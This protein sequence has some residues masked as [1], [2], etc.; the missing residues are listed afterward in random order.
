M[1]WRPFGAKP[2]PEPM[3][4]DWQWDPGK[5]FKDNWFKTWDRNGMAAIFRTTFSNAFSWN[6]SVKISTNISRDFDPKGPVD[7]NEALVQI[8]AW[9]R[10]G[11]E[12]LSKPMMVRWVWRFQ[13]SNTMFRKAC[14]R[15]VWAS[16]VPLFAKENYV[17]R[18]N[19]S[20]QASPKNTSFRE[21]CER[22]YSYNLIWRIM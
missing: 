9:R 1:A 6:E 14:I 21:I 22:I 7:Y 17:M 12:S 15:S 19:W 13:N 18:W 8:M 11:D 5:K 10:S 4:H 3:P 16:V 20:I 2:I